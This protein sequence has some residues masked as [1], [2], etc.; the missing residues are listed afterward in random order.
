MTSPPIPEGFDAI[1]HGWIGW[2]RRAPWVR[3]QLQR[4]VSRLSMGQD[5]L[6]RL[7][8]EEF[9]QQLEAMR[10]AIRRPQG[11]DFPQGILAVLS[12]AAFRSLG[13]R[14]YPVQLLASLAMQKGFLVEMAT[15][16]G[17]TLVAGLAAVMA[18][19]SGKPCHVLTANDYLASRDAQIMAPLFACCGLSVAAIK[20]EMP[21][22][23]RLL[24]YQA[25]VV[26][27]T[28]KD[29]L[30]DF[31]RDQL[32]A[33][34]GVSQ[35][36]K[37][38]NRW[39]GYARGDGQPLLLARGIHTALV[40]EADSLLIDEAVTPLILSAPRQTQG[41]DRAVQVASQVA[42]TLQE[43][44]DYEASIK[45]RHI[46]LK[47]SARETMA[48]V[49]EQLPPLWRAT[50]RREELLRQALVARK[51]F[52][53]NQNYVVLEGKIVLLDEYT[54]RMTPDRTLSAGLHQAIEAHEGVKISQS[55]E[56]LAQ[57]SFQNFFRQFA[58]LSAMTG[59]AREAVGEF[60]HIYRLPCLTV[61]THRPCIRR[62][63]PPK[64]YV[65]EEEKWCGIVA[66]I[67]AIHASRRPVL[68]GTRS[69]R[70]SENLAARLQEQG[71]Q[72]ELLNAVRHQEE[73]RIV[74]TA[75]Q[76]GCI[77]IA[78]NMAGRG[79]DIKLSEIASRQGGLHVIVTEMHDAGRIDRQLLG[80]S[81]RQGDPGSGTLFFCLE[82]ELLIRFLPLPLIKGLKFLFQSGIWGGRAAV[83][84]A[85]SLAQKRA[86]KQARHRRH[87]VLQMDR[88][89]D[90]A[91][92]FEQ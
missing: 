36:R 66:E 47:P 69:V 79:T 46:T 58:R 67:A 57:R 54:G 3:W 34:Q 63:Y 5:V 14:P 6:V 38:F 24:P 92:P 10:Q 41:M 18:A 89:L 88:W 17:K 15:G 55:S 19:W 27:V 84:F 82:D 73:A 1:T 72:F 8:Q 28:A 4:Q 86:E 25:D 51:F 74:A 20:A 76:E 44:V 32:A 56:T 23:E 26:Y 16:E 2:L 12:E 39:L 13:I 7:S 53:R 78:T 62:L 33:R 9:Q 70:A 49:A 50:A 40:D 68:I 11:K 52:I 37:K 48:G 83:I 77:T 59:T 21:P 35:E 22:Q 43:E 31:L 71:L 60:W 85:F 42:A 61:P 29:L 30:G 91:L 90:S 87:D 81:G 65:G 64:V 75:G 45:R 80:R